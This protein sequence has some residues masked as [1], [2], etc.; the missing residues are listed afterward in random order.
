MTVRGFPTSVQACTAAFLALKFA[1]ILGL[2]EVCLGLALAF[3]N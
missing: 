3:L 1:E 2:G